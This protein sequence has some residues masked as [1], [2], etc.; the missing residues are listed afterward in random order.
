MIKL[1]PSL[2]SADFSDLKTDIGNIERG[3]A[4]YLHLDIM[5]GLF[6]PNITFGAPV[7]KKL[8]PISNM[9]F[10]V[11]MMVMNPERY[12]EDFVKAGADII[13]IHAEA[14]QSV[15]N[16]LQKIKELGVSPAVTI[17][18]ATPISDIEGILHLV[19]MVLVMS[20]EPGFGGQKFMPEMLKKCE[21]LAALKKER[22]LSYDVQIDGGIDLKNIRQ[23]LKAGVNV[24]VAGSAVFG[25]PDQEKATKEFL[26]IFKEF[27]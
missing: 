17:K 6:V 16:A 19:D 24:I 5:D 20:V 22:N 27:A 10:D 14:C 9:V 23:V 26:E 12:F 2:L 1:A 3:G 13:N 18:P 11:H 7:I 21:E 15:T 25:A 4:Q 8:R